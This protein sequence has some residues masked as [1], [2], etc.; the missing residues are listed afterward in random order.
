MLLDHLP[1][2]SH[3]RSLRCSRIAL[4]STISVADSAHNVPRM[5]HTIEL[6]DEAQFVDPPTRI[7][8]DVQ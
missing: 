3:G 1:F 6:V 7:I 5:L 8:T 2:F 4:P